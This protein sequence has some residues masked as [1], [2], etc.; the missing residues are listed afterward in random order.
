[1]LLAVEEVTHVERP[2]RPSVLALAVRLAIFVLP[3]VGIACNKDVRT[4]A[5]LES[6]VPFSFVAISILPS[7]H[8][9]AMGFRLE[10]FADITVVMEATP[11]AVTLFKALHP[12]S[13]IDFAVGPSVDP[14]AVCLAHLEVAIIAVAIGVSLEGFAVAEVLQPA[15]L[16]L[17]PVLVLHNAFAIALA[18]N[19]LTD[20]ERA[21]ERGLLEVWLLLYFIQ[22]DLVRLHYDL[23]KL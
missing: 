3:S 16:V 12:L 15:P 11:N 21:L 23:L 18:I 6:H 9:V 14:F 2:V 4:R 19:D 7:V 17:T 8:A 10:P 22:V 13:I 1:M 5:V 20:V